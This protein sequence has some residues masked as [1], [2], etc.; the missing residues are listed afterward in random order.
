MLS[1]FQKKSRFKFKCALVF[2]CTIFM[3]FKPEDKL[4]VAKV[5]DFIVSEKLISLML[6]QISENELLNPV[7]EDL[8]SESGSEIYL[9]N[10][11][12]YIRLSRPV[13]FYTVLEAASRKNDLAIGYKI[14]SEENNSIKNF[15]IYL[16][17][18][19]SQAINFSAGDSVIVL[20]EKK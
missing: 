18:D 19:K 5:D 7:F 14:I 9:K 10:I 3:E 16:N 15:G 13:N 17:P 20:S 4:K 8:L 1:S 12:N 2:S 6:A 11:E